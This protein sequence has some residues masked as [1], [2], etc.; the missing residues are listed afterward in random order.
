MKWLVALSALV[1]VVTAADISASSEIGQHLMAHARR[2]DQNAAADAY[3]DAWIS[4]YSVKFQGCNQIKQ[5]NDNVDNNNDVRIAT[6]RLVRFRLCPTSQCSANKAAGCSKGYGDY[7]IDLETFMSS[8]IEVEQQNLLYKCQNYLSTSCDCTDDGTKGDDFDAAT[9][10]S[11][12]YT[13]GG[14]SDCAAEAEGAFQAANYVQCAEYKAQNN[15]NG[16]NNNGN[17]NNGN[18]YYIGPYCAEQGGGVFLGLFTDDTCTEAASVSFTDLT[19]SELPYSTTSMVTSDCLGCLEQE[20][21]NA[22]NANDQA[23][24]DNVLE[25]CET[26]YTYAGKCEGGLPSGTASSPNNA[27]CNYMEGIRVVRENG[28]IN[29]GRTRPSAV[30]TSFSVIFAMAFCAMAFY[31]WYLRTRLGVKRNALL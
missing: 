3:A 28:V 1:S 17:N 7:V 22:Q 20:D 15:N 18:K 25:S 6:K 9:C 14:L 13:K 30:A 23:D 29:S 16:N 8:Y 10:E 31:V 12:C 26:L 19:G 27:A 5:W 2:L 11:E 24:T 21:A 4:S